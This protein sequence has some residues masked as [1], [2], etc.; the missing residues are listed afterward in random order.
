M[1]TAPITIEP[2]QVQHSAQVAQLLVHGFRGKFQALTSASD[3]TLSLFF[4]RLLAGAPASPTSRR[5]V[6]LHGGEV[7][8]TVSLKRKAGFDTTQQ[9]RNGTLQWSDLRMLGKWNLIKMLIGFYA[10]DHEPRDGECYISDLAVR[11]DQRGNGIG[12]QLLQ[13]A[14]DYV[15]NEP[16]LSML[17]LHVAASNESA[18][19]LYERQSFR[20]HA[21][22]NSFLLRLLFHEPKW[23]YMVL[24]LKS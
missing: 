8:A 24:P 10:L 3:E 9:P 5:L 7:V 15:H 12:G 23:L 22:L 19:Q 4:E 16:S 2:M 11:P 18:R 14:R 1:T 13:W 6:A 20:T 21:E 17:S